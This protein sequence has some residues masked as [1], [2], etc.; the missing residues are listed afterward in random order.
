MRWLSEEAVEFYRREAQRVGAAVGGG[1]YI[2]ADV[3]V[4]PRVRGGVGGL[5][6]AVEGHRERLIAAA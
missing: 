4:D 2:D 6:D 1:G 3:H 5:G